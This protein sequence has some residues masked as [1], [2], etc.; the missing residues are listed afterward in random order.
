MGFK[1]PQSV[2]IV[3]YQK[4]RGFLLLRRADNGLWQSVTGSMQPAETL[5]QTAKRELEEE[6][7]LS[8]STGQL[9][10]TGRTHKYEIIEPW[11][12]RYAPNVT[13]NTE[14][15]FDFELHPDLDAGIHLSPEEH[16]E[17]SWMPGTAAAERVFS[18][19]NREEIQR[20]TRTVYLDNL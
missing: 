15:V 19:T 12:P 13:H 9:V 8:L 1:V 6:T 14:H 3:I 7:G 5:E 2:L 20:I 11:R 4:R 18:R 10:N 17:F 16:T